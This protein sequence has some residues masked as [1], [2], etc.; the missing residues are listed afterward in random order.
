MLLATYRDLNVHEPIR[1][2]FLSDSRDLPPLKHPLRHLMQSLHGTPGE[3]GTR[4]KSRRAAAVVLGI[5]PNA[6]EMNKSLCNLISAYIGAERASVDLVTAVRWLYMR[7]PI[8]QHSDT[9][10]DFTS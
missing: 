9:T 10:I 1:N 3:V 4:W 5:A 7:G 6:Q 8:E 2:Y